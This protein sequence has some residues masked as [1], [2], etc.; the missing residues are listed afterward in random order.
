MARV[1]VNGAC[2]NYTEICCE[3]GDA[4][5]DLVMIHGLAASSG[6]WGMHHA[7][8]FSRYYRVI[9]F[10]LRGHGRSEMTETGYS[11]GNL[12]LDLQQLLDKLGIGKA[13]FV[14]HSFGGVLA[15]KLA[16]VDPRRIS[17]I[18]LADTHITAVR[19]MQKD[20]RWTYGES[21]RPIL[22]R[23]TIM[24]DV[25]DAYFGC[26][27]LT[28]IARRH[29]GNQEL[30][31]DL[32]ELVASF[33]GRFG[34]RSAS[35]WLKLME[36]TTAETEI[37]DDDELS[38]QELKTFRFPILA[39]YGEH[40]QAMLTG[41]HLLGVWPHADFR[42]VRNGG[43]F[44]PVSQPGKFTNICKQFWNGALI[45]NYPRR[46]GEPVQS[47]FRS[48]RMYE[49][50]GR[51][52]FSAREQSRRGPF[53]TIEEAERGLQAHIAQMARAHRGPGKDVLQCQ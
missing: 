46:K 18:T 43:H 44:F 50:A 38:L 15:L 52:F 45:D 40:S 32:R 6:F 33:A 27:L 31:P 5:E 14:A 20:L 22:R 8:V 12:T 1:R 30:A 10:D 11:P 2:I 34:G 7:P 19:N 48:S 47:F 23:N 25:N 28:E 16:L 13:H 51:W 26:R 3:A 37:M 24:L 41:R 29:A 21:I 39:V 42:C 36:R 4:C 9:I 35:Q 53:M 49:D 17:S